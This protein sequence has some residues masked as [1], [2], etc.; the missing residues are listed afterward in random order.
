[1]DDIFSDCEVVCEDQT[2]KLHRN[3]LCT[4]SN[5]FKGPLLHNWQVSIFHLL[6]LLISFISSP[7]YCQESK[8]K[9][10]VITEF[11]KKQVDWLIKFIYTGGKFPCLYC[12]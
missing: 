10:V 3:I 9:Q 8:T 5:Y 7:V 4:R 1:M 12:S 11:S 2:W 6:H